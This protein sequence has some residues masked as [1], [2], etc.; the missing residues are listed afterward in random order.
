MRKTFAIGCAAAVI[1][2]AFFGYVRYEEYRSFFMPASGGTRT[3]VSDGMAFRDVMFT[4]S[5]GVR[6]HGWFV[7]SK[8]SRT[9]VLAC[10]GRR[11]T[12][13]ELVP[14]VRFFHDLGVSLFIFD[15]R[16]YG[17]SEGSPGETGFYRDAQA[18]YRYLT[19]YQKI[20]ARDI[21]IYGVSL[22]GA[23]AIDLA[24]KYPARGLMLEGT[25][26]SARDL[27]A[28]YKPWVPRFL[29]SDLFPSI[30]K[31]PSVHMP[32][33]II[34]SKDDE[35]VPYML[36]RRLADAFAGRARFIEIAG[37]HADACLISRDVCD[38]GM[39]AFFAETKEPS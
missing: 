32:T 35:V 28:V 8:G 20:D 37:K 12:M 3:P 27:A 4:A 36:G 14:R 11:L 17:Q 7:P 10:H 26:T 13:S 2:A 29:V 30:D 19:E 34:H 31:V 38:K 24:T 5:D 22:G 23:V 25:F 18:A 39:R 33:L 1:A 21:V 6:L 9:V 16:G 15:Y